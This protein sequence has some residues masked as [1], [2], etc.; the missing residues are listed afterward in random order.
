MATIDDI[1]MIE[2]CMIM[3]GFGQLWEYDVELNYC[4][5][6]QNAWNDKCWYEL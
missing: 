5:L 2:S 1:I 6:V 3:M 4:D